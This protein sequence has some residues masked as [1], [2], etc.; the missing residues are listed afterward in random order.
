M[1]WEIAVMLAVYLLLVS[2][3][4]WLDHTERKRPHPTRD[5]RDVY[6]DQEPRGTEKLRKARGER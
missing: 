5:L 4:A 1:I 3:A 2:L 6:K